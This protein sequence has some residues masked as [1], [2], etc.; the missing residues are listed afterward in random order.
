MANLALPLMGFKYTPPSLH[1]TAIACQHVCY[2]FTS[3]TDA[4]CKDR[5]EYQPNTGFANQI[6]Q[7]HSN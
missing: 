7:L 3:T 1:K 4:Y 2:P 5:N 6:A